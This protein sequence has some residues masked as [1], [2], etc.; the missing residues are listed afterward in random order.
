MTKEQSQT[1]QAELRKHETIQL[2]PTIQ[3][4]NREGAEWNI[5]CLDMPH[6]TKLLYY[7]GMK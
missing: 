6:K 2:Q 4:Y 1:Y 7:K 5:A 3:E